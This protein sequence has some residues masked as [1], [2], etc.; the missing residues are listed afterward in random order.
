MIT[1]PPPPVPGQT[2]KADLLR[3]IITAIRQCRPIAG[4]GIRIS[5]TLNGAIIAAKAQPSTS[6][7]SEDFEHRFQ[8]AVETN[9]SDASTP[10]YDLVIRKGSLFTIEDAAATQ[11][12][13]LLDTGIADDTEDAD[14]WRV[15]GISTGKLYLTYDEGT[16]AYT[17]HYGVPATG[18]TPLYIIA[19]VEITSTSSEGTTIEVTQRVIGDIFHVL[20]GSAKPAAWTVR[21]N[22]LESGS[23]AWQLHAPLWIN[24]RT[25][26]Y[27]QNTGPG[28]WL[29][30][31]DTAGT[32]YAYRTWIGTFD[33]DGN[34][35]WTPSTD[36][37]QITTDL[38]SVPADVDP[39]AAGDGTT[40]S[41][42]TPAVDGSR[43]IVVTIGQFSTDSNGDTT[44]DQ[45]H[46]GAITAS[47]ANAGAAAAASLSLG[48]PYLNEAGT[49][50]CQDLG[51]YDSEG[52]FT[53]SI[54]EKVKIAVASREVLAKSST[55]ST[56]QS[57]S[58]DTI[59]YQTALL[60]YVSGSL[61]QWLAR[62]TVTPATIT[63][64]EPA[65][66]T[67]EGDIAITQD[68]IEYFAD[69]DPTSTT[70]KPFSTFVEDAN[71][72]STYSA[73]SSSSS[74]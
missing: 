22:T 13:L 10:T 69:V 62:K 70:V 42:T 28:E 4:P 23:T 39:V 72:S 21:L 67:E 66:E 27:Y 9:T 52:N 26:D 37:I 50:L 24:G 64:T 65:D 48:P 43:S 20:S 68:T 2:L 18:V 41:T 31:S 63:V 3:D 58:T 55:D 6:S 35:V 17:L 74:S 25:Q 59:A 32:L 29:T 5:E 33:D 11:I 45:V 19:E 38:S 73:G 34:V 15:S 60:L 56:S 40:S 16:E 49:H 57:S 30:L 12:T 71:E 51:T 36:G 14:C 44:W 54:A 46:L 47:V 8:C 7:T 61:T 53:T 1:L